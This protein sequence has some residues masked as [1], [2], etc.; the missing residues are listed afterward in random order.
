VTVA[1]VLFISLLTFFSSAALAIADEP[2]A[3]GD[4]VADPDPYH[5]RLVT[6]HGTVRQVKALEPYSQTSGTTCYGAYTFTLEDDTGLIGVAVLGVCGKPTI[7]APDVFD[8][9]RVLVQAQILA[10][11]HS[12][13]SG[14]S[15][16]RITLEGDQDKV[17][18]VASAIS[19]LGE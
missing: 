5:L 14:R 12:G 7:K 4:I 10:P 15:G 2:I 9:E 16:G 1:R 3:I 8:G 18:A 11:G 19:H 17:R 13:P 6:L